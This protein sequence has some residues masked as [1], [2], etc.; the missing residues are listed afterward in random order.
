ML[1]DRRDIHLADI[2]KVSGKRGGCRHHRA[3]EMRSAVLAL[4]SLEVAVGSAGAALVG[5]QHVR[6]HADAHAAPRI[7]P[8]EARLAEDAVEALFFGSRFDAARTGNDE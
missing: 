7:A 4:A 6:I 2:D 8:L 1:L 3:D 5:R